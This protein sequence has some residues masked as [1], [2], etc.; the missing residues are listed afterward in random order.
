MRNWIKAASLCLLAAFAVAVCGCGGEKIKTPRRAAVKKT[1]RK[2]QTVKV[3]ETIPTAAESTETIES[4]TTEGEYLTKPFDPTVKKLPPNFIGCDTSEVF[5]ALVKTLGDDEWE[6][7]EYEKKADH[8]KRTLD[9]LAKLGEK[10]LLGNIKVSSLLAFTLRSAN[11]PDENHE[12]SLAKTFYDV[13]SEI[14]TISAGSM[15]KTNSLEGIRLEYLSAK[16]EYVGENGFGVK[17]EV[18]QIEQLNYGVVFQKG[19]H[20]YSEEVVWKLRDVPPDKAKA[21]RDDLGVLCVCKLF[22]DPNWLTIAQRAL[23]IETEDT[24]IEP[25]MDSPLGVNSTDYALRGTEPEFWVYNVK[26]GEVLAKWSWEETDKGVAKKIGDLTVGKTEEAEASPAKTEEK[27]E[28]EGTLASILYASEPFDLTVETLPHNY[29]GHDPEA[30]YKAVDALID[31]SKYKKD[32][33]EKTTD[34]RK[35]VDNFWAELQDKT[36][37]GKVKF[38]SSLAFAFVPEQTVGVAAGP[39]DKP[40]ELRSD[41]NADEETLTFNAY[42]SL[43]VDEPNGGFRDLRGLYFKEGAYGREK[44]GV[45]YTS[46]FINA[47]FK[48]RD[49]EPSVA[50]ELTEKVGALCICNLAWRKGED[51]ERLPKSCFDGK[52]VWVTEPVF[53][54]YNVETGEVLAKYSLN[55]VKNGTPKRIGEQDEY[56]EEIARK[57]IE[58]EGTR[59]ARSCKNGGIRSVESGAREAVENL[60]KERR[61]SAAYWEDGNKRLDNRL[62]AVKRL[63]PSREVAASTVIAVPGDCAT[64]QEALD[65]AAKETSKDE[66][67]RVVLDAGEYDA[68]GLTLKTFVDIQSASGEPGDVV[69]KVDAAKPIVV[70]GETVASFDGVTLRQVGGGAKSGA[71]VEVKRGIAAFFNCDFDGKN[72][73]KS[74]TGAKAVG[75]KSAVVLHKCR[76]AGFSL[77][78]LHVDDGAFAWATETVFGPKNRFGASSK[79][80]RL[81]VEKCEFRENETALYFRGIATGGAQGNVYAENKRDAQIVGGAKVEVDAPN[82]VEE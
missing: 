24:K 16:N 54:L 33:F 38:S 34:Y 19:D 68:S 48:L 7:G 40:V 1:E 32:E 35:R 61:R 55:E 50:K 14:L 6:Q 76:A 81:E 53:W 30:V 78:A 79:A 39:R 29:F 65:E 70:E 64:L 18:T 82:V 52:A 58:K 8:E 59:S 2:T 49:I 22:Y 21:M 20:D 27:P 74:A 62:A 44:G 67:P 9:M 57:A 12:D 23:M 37:F 25:T 4:E 17:K 69:L 5:S 41:Y 60:A 10:T 56:A 46:D 15:M 66:I 72:G 75:L 31:E 47:K 42:A 45:V 36:L 51:N 77:S 71:C 43:D 11:M 13:D 3:D 73:A 63:T 26:T 80:A 28:T